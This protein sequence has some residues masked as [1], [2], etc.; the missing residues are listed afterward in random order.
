MSENEK[1]KSAIDRVTR[2]LTQDH[3]L[4]WEQVYP[5][6]QLSMG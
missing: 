6:Q 3:R 4:G 2:T 1:I 5:K